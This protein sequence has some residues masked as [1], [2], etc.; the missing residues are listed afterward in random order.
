MDRSDITKKFIAFEGLDGCGKTTQATLLARFLEAQ[1]V[2]YTYVREPGGTVVG[3]QIRS[4]LLNPATILSPWGEV[5]L[6]AA[7][8]AQL[9]QDIIVPCLA[10]GDVVVCDRYMFSSLAYQGYGLEQD[11]EF[12]GKVNLQAVRG[13]MPA[14]TFLLQISPEDGLA[15]QASQRGLDRIEQRDAEFFQRVVTG[16]DKMAEKYKFTVLNGTA[17]PE[18]L[19]Q[20]VLALLTNIL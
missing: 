15:R 5:L 11:V 6:Y 7:A 8:R 4:I 13:L 1:G 20:Q 14:W 16:Y 2:K 3:D 12:V 9:V 10:R 18:Q 17:D 19:H